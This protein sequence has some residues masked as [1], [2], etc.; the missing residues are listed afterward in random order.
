M[1][2]RV[3]YETQMKLCEIMN[4]DD[5][6]NV[7]FVNRYFMKSYNKLRTIMF[8]KPKKIV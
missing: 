6:I 8:M 7:K 1:E 5:E 3:P 4:L 2:I